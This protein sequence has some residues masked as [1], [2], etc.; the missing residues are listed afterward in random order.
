MVPEAKEIAREAYT[1][2]NMMTVGEREGWLVKI[3]GSG[4]WRTSSFVSW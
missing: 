1:R 2:R 3:A 4:A